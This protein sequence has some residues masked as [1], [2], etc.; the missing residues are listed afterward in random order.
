MIFWRAERM[1]LI[2]FDI[3]YGRNGL[4]KQDAGKHAKAVVPAQ[5]GTQVATRAAGAD[6]DDART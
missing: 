3:A 6:Y 1:H 5:T 2:V 4:P